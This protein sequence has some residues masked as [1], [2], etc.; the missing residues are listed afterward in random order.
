[1]CDTIP[2]LNNQVN[3]SHF[4]PWFINFIIICMPHETQ[5]LNTHVKYYMLNITQM[6]SKYLLWIKLC[7]SKRHVEVLTRTCECDFIQK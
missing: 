7:P 2:I 5:T 4:Y 6:Y 3:V 1:M